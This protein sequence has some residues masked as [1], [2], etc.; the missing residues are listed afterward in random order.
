MLKIGDFSKLSKVSVKTLHH[1]DE[2]GLLKPDQVNPF[3]GYRYYSADQLPRLNRILD[4]KELGL[5]LEQIARIL[6]EDISEDEFQ[7]ILRLKQVELEGK[8]QEVQGQLTR[9]E[10]RLRQ[11]FNS[12]RRQQMLNLK[13]PDSPEAITPEWL[14][15]AL[16]STDTINGAIVSSCDT[17]RVG[18][19]HAGRMARVELEYEEYEEGA[20][21]SI[22]AR[23][24]SAD[25]ALLERYWSLQEKE[26]RFYQ[27]IAGEVEL[28]TPR[29]Y[30]SAKDP[31]IKKSIFLLEDLAPARQGSIRAGCSVKEANLVLRHLA[32][33]QA[34]F[35]ENQRLE[36]ITWLRPFSINAEAEKQFQ[37]KWDVFI[38]KYADS[39]PD[40]ILPIGEKLKGNMVNI[41]NLRNQ[42]PHTFVHS[43]FHLNHLFFCGSKEDTE[44][45]V[46]DWQLI[47]RGSGLWDVASFLAEGLDPEDRR[48][49]ESEL[50]KTYHS[51]LEE[52]GVKGFGFD[53]L[54]KG[55]QLS[56][57]GVWY[58]VV[59]NMVIFDWDAN[60]GLRESANVRVRRNSAAVLDHYSDD[61]IA[62]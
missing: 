12:F 32:K 34:T 54:M 17:T 47:S 11:T 26:V 25:A 2:V 58:W 21:R 42:G 56:I 14:T 6:E 61:L 18:S 10:E 7:G 3:T 28:R 49:N 57:L 15:Q 53:Q 8:M 59:F 38:E 60:D 46:F 19:G 52:H 23:F 4:L 40:T 41:I 29:F 13:I 44:I 5:S 62:D 30:Y 43:D 45:A 37:E 51:A 24:P 39:V 16:K 33:F 27:E 48:E 20:P 31:E 55:Y 9:V 35:W 36:A 50:L 1:Y 22:I